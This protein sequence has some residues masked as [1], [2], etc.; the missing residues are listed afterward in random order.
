MRLIRLS[1]YQG[2]RLSDCRFSLS[3]GLS[4]YRISDWRILETIGLSDIGSRTQCIGLSEADKQKTV[5][6]LALVCIVIELTDL[7][8]AEKCI[9][10]PKN[11]AKRAT[12]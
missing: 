11:D 3:L 9:Q 4:Q 1:D 10:D 7:E 6:C 2:L 8:N 12:V 5:C